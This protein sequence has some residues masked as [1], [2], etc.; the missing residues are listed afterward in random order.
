MNL[1][2]SLPLAFLLLA[3]RLPAQVT[4]APYNAA[5]GTTPDQQGWELNESPIGG[6]SFSV[7]NGILSQS[8]LPNTST[9]CSNFS[10]PQILRWQVL[11][12]TFDFDL[13][14]TFE[15]DVLI[16]SS[17]YNTDECD[18]SPRAGF[19]MVVRDHLSRN[20]QVGLGESKVYLVNDPFVP[21]GD[22]GV[23]EVD[24]DTTDDFHRYHLA[25]NESGAVLSIDGVTQLSLPHGAPISSPNVVNIGD[26][27]VWAN[28]EADIRSFVFVGAAPSGPWSNRGHSLA[29]SRGSPCF[30]GSGSLLPGQVSNW[31]LS[32]ARPGAPAFWV[33]G[34]SEINAPFRGG[35]FVPSPDVLVPL[36]TGAT[37][38]LDFSGALPAGLP[39][40][41]ELSWQWWIS[42]PTGPRGLTA[43][44]G[45][46]G[47]IQ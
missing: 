36:N 12:R 35:V 34:L 29:G 5:L 27:T 9:S 40:G 38:Q 25:V 32:N 26:S 28:S 43:S 23:V 7:A 47:V 42:D 18:D 15:A 11:N 37:G 41:T 30:T 10:N 3:S 16:Q 1:R 33:W 19:R 14:T 6:G 20:F 21:F 24:F 44:N 45:L 31:T 4:C 46:R 13:G 22:P 17:Q 8:S 39:S 2:S